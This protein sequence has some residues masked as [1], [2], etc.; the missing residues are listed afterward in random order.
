MA[1][2]FP[3]IDP[4]ALEIGPLAVRWYALS[5]MVGI[6]LGW[7][8]ALNLASKGQEGERP[9]A[10]EI[11][12][13]IT[14]AVLGVIAGGR[15]GYVLFYAPGLYLE[16][17][18]EALMVWK[19]GMSFHGGML[20]VLLA[21]VLYARKRQIPL[22]RLSDIVCAAV[23]IGLFFGRLANFV[24]A[25]LYGKHTD[26]WWGVI[27]PDGSGLPRHPSQLYEAFLEGIVLFILLA[28]LIKKPSIRNRPGIVSGIFLIG[29]GTFRFLVETVREPDAQIG[30][31]AN[32]VTMGQML[33]LP[34]IAIGVFLAVR[35]SR[36]NSATAQ[37]KP[38]V[39]A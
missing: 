34:M 17:P 2:Q 15:L 32:L 27:F 26:V 35:S 10:T 30:Y 7:R 9:S 22:L 4:I 14:W 37:T 12:D 6:L 38:H 28:V 3:E 21:M 33:C 8:Y 25:E 36:Q 1:F 11:D 39:P 18:L 20:G 19:G 13:F 23:P 29:Y 5:Y 24:N 31:I 16:S